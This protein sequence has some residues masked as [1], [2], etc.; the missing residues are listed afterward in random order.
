MKPTVSKSTATTTHHRRQPIQPIPRP[1]IEQSVA[2]VARL[3]K[4]DPEA[5]AIF[6]DA[7]RKLAALRER[8]KAAAPKTKTTKAVRTSSPNSRTRQRIPVL[9]LEDAQ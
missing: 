4:L 2:E 1:R 8:R 6:L 9:S 3:R 7:A 5:Y